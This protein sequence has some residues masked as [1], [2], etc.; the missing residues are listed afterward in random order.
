M[1]Q[2]NINPKISIVIPIY[3]TVR[4]LRKCLSSVC[5]QTYRNLEIIGVDDGSTDGSREILQEFADGDSRVIA[6]Y[7]ENGGE[8]SAR[9]AGLQC[10][11]GDYIGFMDCD[12]WIER[13]MYELLLK[14]A[15][16]SSVDVVAC[17][18]SL[19]TDTISIPAKN[20]YQV[21]NKPF[22]R[23]QLLEYVYRRDVYRAFTGYIWCKLYRRQVLQNDD[24]RWLQF[25]ESLP[26]GG[27]IAFFQR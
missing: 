25:D 10:C 12:D 15:E 5:E 24:G 4:Y 16:Q 9:N 26:L 20:I 1:N 13:D 11:T 17:G 2:K 18:Y 27:D 14:C 21:T 7:K 19:D 6:I 22:N 23:H 8:S 3:N